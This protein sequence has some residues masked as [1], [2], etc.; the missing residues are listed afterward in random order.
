MLSIGFL[1]LGLVLG[2]GM[3]FVR[4]APGEPERAAKIVP[5]AIMYRY[6]L[7]RYFVALFG[8]A[9][10]FFGLAGLVGWIQID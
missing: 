10:A 8:F 4:P 2:F 1:V 3:I 5:W 7:F 9:F 6:K